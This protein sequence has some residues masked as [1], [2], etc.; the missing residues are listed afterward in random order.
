[1]SF[2]RDNTNKVMWL[3][4]TWSGFNACLIINILFP[5]SSH[6]FHPVWPMKKIER[7]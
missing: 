3:Q 2:E 5:Y 6:S 7:V 1:M 4:A